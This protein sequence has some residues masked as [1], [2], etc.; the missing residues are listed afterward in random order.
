[1]SEKSHEILTAS[2]GLPAFSARPWTGEKHEALRRYI[3]ITTAARRKYLPSG[4]GNGGAA[5]IDLYTGPGLVVDRDTGI[6]S[7]GTVLAAAETAINSG[8]PFS[9]FV[10]GDIK[11]EHVDVAEVRLRHL[12]EKHD[13]GSTPVYTMVSSAADSALQLVRDVQ[14]G[15][16]AVKAGG[17]NLACLDPFNLEH[18]PFE[19]FSHLAQLQRIDLFVHISGST[20]QRNLPIALE[21][22]PE[23]AGLEAFAPGWVEKVDRTHEQYRQ[24]DEFKQHWTS[25]LKEKGYHT[26][27]PDW[28]DVRN[29]TGAI[30][31]W[32]AVVSKHPLAKKL[33]AAMN[34]PPQR[35]LL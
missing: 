24:R 21:T 25:L 35:S 34:A 17:L 8:A 14:S 11:K 29:T 27:I 7:S 5:Y 15:R 20:L 33:W 18:L 31:Y 13:L 9:A 28:V 10:L 12:L 32:L 6:E 4:G 16:S 26:Q 23:R 19:V 3:N 22:S 2:D 1:M 30:N